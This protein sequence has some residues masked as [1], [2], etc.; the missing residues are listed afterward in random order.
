MLHGYPSTPGYISFLFLFFSVLCLVNALLLD[1]KKTALAIDGVQQC[2][3]CRPRSTGK[4]LRDG[5]DPDPFGR[6]S[7]VSDLPI[8]PPLSPFIDQTALLTIA[9]YRLMR[10]YMLLREKLAGSLFLNLALVSREAY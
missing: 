5:N 4:R 8:N 7:P 1:L 9:L 6:K 10:L 2:M 3:S